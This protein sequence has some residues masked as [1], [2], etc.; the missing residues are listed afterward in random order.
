MNEV[1]TSE[2][3]KQELFP[4]VTILDY[5]GYDRENI[6]FSFFEEKVT[7]DEFLDRFTSCTV[8]TKLDYLPHGA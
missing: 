4:K 2:Q 1:K 5:D 8:I 6:Q 3:W 7:K